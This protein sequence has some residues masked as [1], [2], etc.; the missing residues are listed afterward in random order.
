MRLWEFKN[1]TKTNNKNKN[2]KIMLLFVS[3]WTICDVSSKTPYTKLSLRPQ[4]IRQIY[5][6]RLM[7]GRSH[8]TFCITVS[9]LTIFRTPCF[10][11]F[12]G[13]KVTYFT[14]ELLCTLCFSYQMVPHP[15]STLPLLPFSHFCTWPLLYLKACKPFITVSSLHMHQ[16]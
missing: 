13:G 6:K 3:A 16:P 15:Q 8:F 9:F 7:N 5:R 12:Q 14:F 2:W 11:H 4:T 1:D 10:W